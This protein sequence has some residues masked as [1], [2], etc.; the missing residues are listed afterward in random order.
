VDPGP[1]IA[2]LWIGEDASREPLHKLM[3]A[4]MRELLPQYRHITVRA[5][6]RSTAREELASALRHHRVGMIAALP[7]GWRAALW[8]AP[9]RTMAFNSRGENWFIH[10]RTPI[11][12]WLFLRGIR[13]DRIALRPWF[14]PGTRK[15]T[16]VP[17]S[18]G[19][20]VGRPASPIRAPFAVLS[21]Y[22]PWPLGHGGA[23]RIFSLLR[24]AA[25]DFDI[26]L[27]VFTEDGNAPDPGPLK[28]LCHRITY[29]EK[30]HYWEPRW[31]TLTPPEV[32]EY[33]SPAMAR[34]LRNVQTLQ[35]EYTQLANYSQR[36]DAILVEHDITC[37]LYAQIHSRTRTLGSWWD[38]Y[39]W[40]R[41]EHRAVRRAQPVV[42]S[43]KDRGMLGVSG[44]VIIGNGVDLDRFQP[45]PERPG[46]R[47]LFVGSFRH[48]PNIEAFVWFWNE[49]WPL[50]RDC[51]LTVVAGPEPLVHWRNITGERE[52]PAAA[53]LT[54]HGFV[55]DVKPLYDET[56]IV[57]VPTLVSAGTNLK[58]LEAMAMQRAIVTT[59][60]GIAGIGLTHGNDVLI[61]ET[62]GG[63]AA[64]I[65]ELLDDPARRTQLASK[66]SA[67]A[68]ANFS[69]K[70]L[71][72][73]QAKLWHRF[74][75]S[76]LTIEPEPSPTTEF[77]Q[78]PAL[79]A[80]LNGKL[81]AHLTWHEL[82]AASDGHL[83]EYEVLWIEADPSY[84]RMGL[85]GRLLEAA[86]A[87][88][89]GRWFLEV[90]ETNAAARAL[91]TKL[92]FQ[93]TG[94]RKGYYSNPEEDAVLMQR[95][96]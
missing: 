9:F 70:S 43:E 14:W 28:D 41:F 61:A 13:L 54:L 52:L 80:R 12:S 50:L 62:P 79:V 35:I 47:I 15:Q 93:E 48:F 21:P 26:D 81:V 69:W 45:T 32:C 3:Q 39:R 20:I 85:A 53:G 64:C 2:T 36:P 63:F 89:L 96:A 4:K 56:N 65:E 38:L 23:V 83:A 18:L 33:R 16:F 60:S 34:A 6:S 86:L 46:R 29:V 44:S 19:V 91:Y 74:S 57:I 51:E 84:R 78:Y 22:M 10:W 73:V 17:D 58:V 67:L 7:E 40:K 5:A 25:R 59:P 49:V 27:Y 31:S 95:P 11:C 66:A 72:A 94:H 92:Q 90:R 24:E 55:S 88:H 87:T 42:M 75:P 76:P 68:H 82:A 1:V 37:D 30:P 71:G 8:T 77:A